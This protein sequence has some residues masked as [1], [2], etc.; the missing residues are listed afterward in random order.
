MKSRR[1]ISRFDVLR[2]L[3]KDARRL[4]R[5]STSTDSSARRKTA[6]L[7]RRLEKLIRILNPLANPRLALRLAAIAFGGLAAGNLQAQTPSLLSASPTANDVN[8]AT[9][10][11]VTATFDT[12]M[13]SDTFSSGT[14]RIFGS[15]T[16][17]LSDDGVY[18]GVTT[19]VFNPDNNFKP[20]EKI[21]V[22]ITTGVESTSGNA[23]GTPHVFQFITAVEYGSGIF[24][25]RALSGTGGGNAA[26]VGDF[27]GD[28]SP[29]VIVV[30]ES[31]SSLIWLNNG[32]GTLSETTFGSSNN[33]RDVVSGDLDGDGD[34][35]VV[36]VNYNQVNEVWL[37]NGDGTFTNGI[38]GSGRS[39]AVDIGD[40]DGDGDLDIVHT[41]SRQLDEVWFNNGDATFSIQTFGTAT[42]SLGT[43]A[44]LYSWDAGI[45]DLDNDGDLDVIVTKFAAF[46]SYRQDIWLNDG[47]GTLTPQTFAS[48]VNYQKFEIADLDGDDDL[49]FILTTGTPVI[50]KNNGDATFASQ[51]LPAFDIIEM[52]LGDLDGDGDLDM[53]S[54]GNTSTDLV[55]R[56][57]GSMNFV[58]D[59]IGQDAGSENGLG[60]ISA[61]ADFDGDGDLDVLIIN[62]SSSPNLWLND[63]PATVTDLSPDKNSLDNEFNTEVRIGFL[64]TMQTST[65]TIN[66]VPTQANIIVYG[67]QTGHLGTT[68]TLTFEDD[69]EIAVITPAV[70]FKPGEL[71]TVTVTGAAKFDGRDPKELDKALVYSFMIGADGGTGVFSSSG[72]GTGEST[73]IAFGDIDGDGDLDAIVTNYYSPQEIWLNNGNA[74]FATS[75]L[76]TKFSSDVALGDLDGDGDLDAVISAYFG[77]PQEVW[78]NNG[79]GTFNSSTFG[80]GSSRDVALG[81][82]DGDGDLDVVIANYYDEAEHIWFNNGDGTFTS[83]TLGAGDSK[84][85]AIGDLDGDCDLDVVITNIGGADNIWLNNGGGQFSTSSFGAGDGQAVALGDLDGDGD[86]DAII[87][88]SN[89]GNDVWK[90]NGDASFSLGSL[91]NSVD[92]DVELGDID[93]DGDLDAIT[94]VNG[95]PQ[96]IWTNNGDATFIERSFGTGDSRGLAIGDLDGDGDLDVAVMNYVT[97]DREIWINSGTPRVTSVVPSTNANSVLQDADIQINFNAQ[98]ES[99]TLTTSVNIADA[100]FI[101]HGMQTGYM[102]SNAAVTVT[103]GNM[104]AIINPAVDYHAGELVMV[105]V[106][107]AA[108]ANGLK[109]ERPVV[110]SFTAETTTGSGTFTSTS[111]G[112]GGSSRSV[113][114]GDLDGDGDLDAIVARYTNQPRIHLNNGDGTFASTGFGPSGLNLDVAM[115]DLDGDGTL[116]AVIMNGPVRQNGIWLNNG[117][118]TFN[119]ST[120]GTDDGFAVDLGDLDGDGD[121]DAIVVTDGPNDRRWINDGNGSFVSS[122]LGS[123]VNGTRDQVDV[124]IG[125][126]DNDGDLDAVTAADN[127]RGTVTFLNNGDGSFTQSVTTGFTAAGVALGDLNNDGWL[128][129]VW[130]ISG[131]TDRLRLN[132]GSGSLNGEVE[133]FGDS[134]SSSS[135]ALGD[136]D[137]DGD[138]DMIFGKDSGGHHVFFNNGD[139]TFVSSS[140]SGS[141]SNRLA[142]GDLDD[143]DDLDFI[144]ANGATAAVYLNQPL[145]P[146][147]PP[148]FYPHVT[149]LSPATNANA[150]PVDSDI[151]ISF[152][153]SMNVSSLS[154]TNINIFGSF[155]GYLSTRGV[156]S[157]TNPR[158]FNPDADF[159]PGELISVTVTGAQ[160]LA[161]VAA[162]TATVYSFRAKVTNGNATFD[163]SHL[164]FGF[165]SGLD[166]G[167]VDGDG[168]LDAIVAHGAFGGQRLWLNNGDGSFAT[169]SQGDGR[170]TGVAMGDLD[171]DGDLDAM[172]SRAGYAEEI[173]LNNGD[174]SFSTS[175]AGNSN[176]NSR[177]LDLGDLDGDGDLDAIIANEGGQ[178]QAVMLNNGD[179][180]FDVFTIGSSRGRDVAL[181][182]LDGDGDLD[183][184]VAGY[185]SSSELMLN[186][187]DGS[188]AVSS[189]GITRIQRT[190]V[191]VGDLDGDGDLDVVMSAYDDAQ[192]IWFND[193]TGVLTSSSFASWVSQDV[194]L[195]DLDGDGDLDA[196]FAAN[197]ELSEA[198]EGGGGDGRLPAALPGTT[199]HNEEMIW[200]NN[201]D[202]SFVSFVVG[203]GESSA[204]SLGDLDGDG[205]LDALVVNDEGGGAPA[206]LWLN[207]APVQLLS[208]TPEAHG[209]NVDKDADIDLV[210]NTAINPTT[211]SGSA[212]TNTAG[213]SV[214]GSQTGNIAPSATIDFATSTNATLNPAADFKAGEKIAV[215]VS[216]PEAFSGETIANSRVQEFRAKVPRGV[217]IF[218]SVSVTGA[219][220]GILDQDAGDVDGDGFVDLVYALSGSRLEVLSNNAGGDIGF[221]HASTDFSSGVIWIKLGDLDGDGDLDVFS[222]GASEQAVLFNDGAGNFS[223]NTVASIASLTSTE[224]G[225]IDADGDLDAVLAGY[226]RYGV[227]FNDGAGG[228]SGSSYNTPVQSQ[229]AVLGDLD[230]DGDL[231]LLVVGYNDNNRVLLNNGDGTFAT[232]SA[233]GSGVSYSAALGDLDGDGDLD[234]VV[235]N[236]NGTHTLLNNQG[237]A[238]FTTQS[239][240]AANSSEAIVELGDMD[241]DGDLDIVT[242]YDDEPTEFCRNLGG[243]NF[244]R[245][246]LSAGDAVNLSIADF[247]N[248]NDLDIAESSAALKRAWENVD[249]P[250]VTELSPNCVIETTANLSVTVSGEN[251]VETQ[252]TITILNSDGSDSGTTLSLSLLSGATTNQFQTVIPSGYVSTAGTL[253]LTVTGRENRTTT[254]TLTVHPLISIVGNICNFNG[255]DETYNVSPADANAAH[256]WSVTNGEIVGSSSGSQVVVNWDDGASGTLTLLR[257]YTSGCTTATAFTVN[258]VGIPTIDDLAFTA[259]NEPVT[260]AV[261][262]NDASGLSLLSVSSPDNG[263]AVTSG[264]TVVYTPDSGFVGFDSMTYTVENGD[265]CS[266]TG[267]ITTAVGLGT[268]YTHNLVWLE[269]E[270][271]RVGGV[272]GLNRAVDVAVSPDGKHLYASGRNDHSIALFNIDATTGTIEYVKRVRNGRNG[273]NRMRY[274][275]SLLIS[276]DGENLYVLSYGDNA[277]VVFDRNAA[278]GDLSYVENKRNGTSDAGGTIN[279][280]KGPRSLA[281]SDDQENLYV[282][283]QSNNGLVVFERS[284]TSGTLTFL[285]SFKDGVD[286]VD[287]L[288]EILD[289]QVS[290]DDAHV[291]AAGFGEDEIAIFER[292]S[293]NGSLTYLERV[294]DGVDGVDG[295]ENVAGLALSPD[296]ANLYAVSNG[297]NA[298]VTFARESTNGSLSFVELVRDGSGGVD[299]LNGARDV[300]L[301]SQ[302]RELYVSGSIDDAIAGFARSASGTLCFNGASVDGVDGVDGI[303]NVRGLAVTP[304]GSYIYGAGYGE[305]S[306]AAFRRNYHPY[307]FDDTG[308]NVPANSSLTISVLTNDVDPDGDVLT[309]SSKTNG[310]LGTVSIVNS[311]TKLEYNS[312]SSSGNDTFTYTISDGNGGSSTASV[313][314]L[315][316]SSGRREGANEQDVNAGV[317]AAELRVSPNPTAGAATV[318]FHVN[319]RSRVTARIAALTGH[320]LWKAQLGDLN[321]GMHAFIWQGL[322]L[323]GHKLP[324]GVYY[325]ELTLDDGSGNVQRLNTE[326]VIKR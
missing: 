170:G 156:L 101:V 34:L 199:T 74:S 8:A 241:G 169:S 193:G 159:L 19:A 203:V 7:R 218:E 78:L 147:P 71:V 158:V 143:D 112:G 35:D 157:S 153:T 288:R 130:A 66:A 271:D 192:E 168:D 23:L 240:P 206:Q 228:F 96:R 131:D 314:V 64:Q 62:S 109:I 167:D 154:S 269:R 26:T 187:G 297:G 202:G 247:D 148:V 275:E 185:Y 72:F 38:F 140:F 318:S 222:N 229:E 207:G 209:N 58:A 310:S 86:L 111:I 286:G 220:V 236:T 11:N 194:Q 261:L 239:L 324:S 163:T 195:G 245:E 146:P 294:R 304:D 40:M 102:S 106:T 87:A 53:A 124:A 44:T 152:S 299:G 100:N 47:T 63:P 136:L 319:K 85:V 307:A 325:L 295:L 90:N 197:G 173:W 284:T 313:S 10:A 213:I 61:C 300:I 32:D 224:L 166:L 255:I 41:T 17:F 225:D 232:G 268:K 285:E 16:G 292:S 52:S 257:T 128:D 28:G 287:G 162:S 36:V 108:V 77:Y 316:L 88:R 89:T 212:N 315:V 48:D 81:D 188:F 308:L 118:G 113:A 210:F 280:M 95:G 121:L 70:D 279:R 141:A 172:V 29:D 178:A 214:F 135:V 322:D 57:N 9:T 125:D 259:V 177:G 5:F 205:D 289:V 256:A 237:N 273:V 278:T 15:Q 137:G 55:F 233:A 250:I 142:M 312:G 56:N 37:N 189:F 326:V 123:G 249:A 215:T 119:S 104:R 272:R 1:L 115:G 274:P 46:S 301:D 186:N 12:A 83:T 82:L 116:D 235:A 42:S 145:P 176:G 110:F 133:E 184:V 160:S 149:T 251:F 174:G 165:Y 276:P 201:G 20:G 281:L 198:S 254:T 223:L 126:L 265:G 6:F 171:N 24:A 97:N 234:A 277:V 75:T 31:A 151:E 117:N 3:R 216:K 138:L 155:S 293:T 129:A 60:R 196:F 305:N 227:L 50:F 302:G 252:A 14:I 242:V 221:T 311:S 103:N 244:D 179:A 219:N 183:A 98:M 258:P 59:A 262:F 49:D 13:D 4:H 290:P 243:F 91:G 283:G 246:Q 93:G 264:N 267:A 105:T 2:R 30:R 51:S 67:S 39:T 321:A 217:A 144:S 211:L 94:A 226:D 76:G 122:P 22:S 180:T 25:Q 260:I 238:I 303:D 54:A 323:A 161:G 68:A 33:S 73:N 27:D 139:A 65:L 45:G 175:T 230:S 182:D 320:E 79:D 150:A 99:T 291:Y 282:A 231:D 69:D 253:T 191:D 164:D 120:F 248:D 80:S 306:V 270:K 107:N 181:G 200:L 21:S 84:G 92:H 298:L 18:S 208:V 134:S 132:N 204:A 127:S 317:S 309:I 114:I 296:G 43:F 266:V 190:A 263:S